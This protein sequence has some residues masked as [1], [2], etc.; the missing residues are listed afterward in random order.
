MAEIFQ[1]L[2]ATW[3]RAGLIQRVLLLGV[4][5]GCVGAAAL[6]I[7]WARTPNMALLYSGLGAEEAAKIVE[8]IRDAE[9]AYELKDGG[10]TIYVDEQ[11]VYEMRLTMAG[12]GLPTGDQ[13][14]YSILDDD[15]FG[16]SPFQQGIKYKRAQEGELARSIQSIDGVIS[17]RVHVVKPEGSLFKGKGKG[18][19]ASVSLKLKSGKHMTGSNISAIVHLVAGGVEGLEPQNVTV[20]DSAGPTLLSGGMEDD[21]AKGANTFHE[22]K[23]QVEEYLAKK[24]EDVLIPVLGPG[25]ASVRVSATIENSST[26]MTTKTLGEK[27]LLREE[28]TESSEAPS[29][30]GGD[31]TEKVKPDTQN[32][33]SS[34]YTVPETLEEKTTP[35]GEITDI[36][37]AAVVDLTGQA[38]P[39]DDS[40]GAATAALTVDD[41]KKIIQKAL[42]LK[43]ATSIEVYSAL[44]HQPPEPAEAAEPGMFSLGNILKLLRHISLGL[45]VIGALLV[46]KMFGAKKMTKAEVAAALE[47]QPAGAERLLPV[48]GVGVDSEILRTRITHALQENPEEVKRLF[49]SWVEG[50][51]GER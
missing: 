11:K 47:G 38:T 14:G 49:L 21:L 23:R 48:S 4:L 50:E 37:V 24:A 15:S 12:Q 17:A 32:T 31:K 6:L 34:E 42:G 39:E 41:V 45:L 16:S 7:N 43:D 3:Q 25:R 29:R 33:M 51:K 22:Y 1:N 2:S 10:T 8:K 5:L 36:Q 28:S 20:I 26:R 46:L 18:A 13:G 35:P 27:V 40:G 9:I 19:S 44:F 30:G